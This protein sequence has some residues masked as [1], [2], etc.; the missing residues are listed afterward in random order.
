[1]QFGQLW[2]AEASEWGDGENH[3]KSELRRT[4]TLDA[5]GDGDFS[6]NEV[7]GKARQGELNVQIALCSNCVGT[8]D[9]FRLLWQRLKFK[10]RE[11]LMQECVNLDVNV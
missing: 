8:W 1:M 5:D 4:N 2:L 3:R 6:T 7:T 11:L 9:T 10:L